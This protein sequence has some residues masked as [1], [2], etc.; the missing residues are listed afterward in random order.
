MLIACPSTG[1]HEPALQSWCDTITSD[2]GIV[3]AVE[4]TIEGPGAGYLQKVDLIHRESPP[5]D[6][7]C[8]F[9]SDLF[10]QQA[11][12]DEMVQ[13]E[14]RDPSVV[15]ASFCGAFWHGTDD[16][17]RRPYDFRQLA[18]HH[19]VSNMDNAEA[20]GRRLLTA[21]NVAV[22]DSMAIIVRRSFLDEIGG[23]PVNRYPPSHCSDYYLCLMA[24]K[25][26]RKVRYIPVAV[27]HAGGGTKG[28]GRFDYAAW[29]AGTKWMSDDNC[30]KLGH[31]LIYHD[32]RN[33]LPVRVGLPD[34]IR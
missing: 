14:F 2:P 32:F 13:Y 25:R 27:S 23:W 1:G 24:H 31:W 10:I 16:I 21:C 20:H 26:G 34:G 30:H 33:I 7:I 28:D 12:W 8:Y 15:V 9:H 11:A 18:R 19:F 17:Y 3:F 29:I 6:L 4:D 5:T 22:V